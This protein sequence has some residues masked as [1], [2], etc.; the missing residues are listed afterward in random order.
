[1]SLHADGHYVTAPPLRC[2][3]C[4]RDVFAVVPYTRDLVTGRVL[5]RCCLDCAAEMARCPVPE[6]DRP[7]HT[8]LH[9]D[10]DGFRWG[11]A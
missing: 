7:T 4:A 1:M 9:E 6:C 2:D 5:M 10:A 11:A 3:R 8:G